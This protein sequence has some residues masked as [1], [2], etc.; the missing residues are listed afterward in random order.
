LPKIAPAIEKGRQQDRASR[1]ERNR[2]GVPA[3]PGAPRNGILIFCSHFRL[4]LEGNLRRPFLG[5]FA[6]RKGG[7][8]AGALRRKSAVFPGEI[9]GLLRCT[10]HSLLWPKHHFSA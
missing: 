7:L 9:A 8:F 10:W 4:R 5:W 2:A 1:G 6:L 3:I